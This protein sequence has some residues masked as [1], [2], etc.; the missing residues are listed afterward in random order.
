MDK[1][2]NQA[3]WPTTIES[4]KDFAKEALDEMKYRNN[5]PALTRAVENA[6]SVK[7]VQMIVINSIL[8]GEGLKVL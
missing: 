8:S 5:V 2:I 1:Y 3:N 4:A 6:T 7:R